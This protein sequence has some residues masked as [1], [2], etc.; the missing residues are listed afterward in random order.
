MWPISPWQI[1]YSFLGPPWR[2]VERHVGVGG[3]VEGLEGGRSW[4]MV[5]PFQVSRVNGSDIP[6]F[7]KV[8]YEAGWKGLIQTQS[9]PLGWRTD[10]SPNV[11]FGGRR[12]A[13]ASS[14]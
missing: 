6:G 9:C 14:V 5:L 3:R 12:L 8:S 2:F 11:T 4:L 10:G 1:C 13:A 7:G